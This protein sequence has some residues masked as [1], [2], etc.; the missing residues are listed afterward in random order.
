MRVKR[1]QGLWS[2]LQPKRFLNPLNPEYALAGNVGMLASG[3]AH[4]P[5]ATVVDVMD[6][7]PDRLVVKYLGVLWRAKVHRHTLS[8]TIGD[9]VR[10]ISRQGNVLIVDRGLPQPGERTLNWPF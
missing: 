1:L 8:L 3:L 5:T 4:L 2:Y 9:E 6:P 10:V 7:H